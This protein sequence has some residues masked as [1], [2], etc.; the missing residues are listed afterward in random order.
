M[1]PAVFF[2]STYCF[3]CLSYMSLPAQLSLHVEPER[4]V[5]FGQDTVGDGA[6]LMWIPS[7]RAF[8]AGFADGGTWEYPN[9]GSESMAAGSRTTASGEGSTALG[10]ITFATGRFSTAMGAVTT[11]AGDWSTAMGVDTR[12]LGD[13][14]TA[15]GNFTEASGPHSTSMGRSTIASGFA[16]TAVGMFN[17]NGHATFDVGIG[18]SS[19][20][21]LS[22]L[23]VFSSGN[24]QVGT[25]GEGN[26]LLTLDSER[27]WVF[28]QYS[29][30]SST[31]LK[32][33]AKDPA[34]NNKNFLID[35]D[36]KVGINVDEPTYK[37]ELPNASHIAA[38]QARANDWDT[39]SDA[40]VKRSVT[41]L[42]DALDKLKR[43]RPVIYNHH[44]SEFRDDTLIVHPEEYSREIG[45]IA[46]EVYDIFPELVYCPKNE[47]TDLWS[48]SYSRLVA[49]LTMA[50]Q[51]QQT[52]IEEQRQ[53]IFQLKQEYESRFRILDKRLTKL[54]ES[55]G[56][57][58]FTQ[59]D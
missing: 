41:E 55:S 53:S 14:S 37:L 2:F 19:T 44:T 8:R 40:R 5:L 54:E 52:I 35:T 13:A 22:A 26:V 34:N 30:T 43:L 59:D 49:V 4:T 10:R 15:L 47:K 12:A 33:T 9:I 24:V 17:K 25:P 6:K 29:K 51:E 23:T 56:Q 27:A 39:Y 11:A 46:Q 32:L 7:K 42:G 58:A 16:S 18:S 3:L 50:L 45:F 38:G 48:M 20:D 21:R 57:E 36:G 1:H 28:K 31:A